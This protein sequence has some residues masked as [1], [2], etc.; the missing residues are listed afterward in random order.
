MQALGPA[1]KAMQ[2]LENFSGMNATQAQQFETAVANNNYAGE[3]QALGSSPQ[4]MQALETFLRHESTQAQQFDTAVANNN[5]AGELQALGSSPQSMQALESF[6]ASQNSDNTINASQN[7]DNAIPTFASGDP[8][9]VSA[10]NY[11]TEYANAVDGSNIPFI[12]PGANTDARAWDSTIP[13]FA[14]GDPSNVSTTNYPTEAAAL[15]PS[16]DPSTSTGYANGAADFASYAAVADGSY[17]VADAVNYPVV[18][19]SYAPGDVAAD[20]ASDASADIASYVSDDIAAYVAAD[21]STDDIA[22]YAAADIANYAAADIANYAAADIANYA[23]SDVANYAAA[24]IA[25]YAAADIASYAAAGYSP[26][27]IASHVKADIASY[28]EADI[29]KYAT[30]AAADSAS[31]VFAGDSHVLS[32]EQPDHQTTYAMDYSTSHDI[33]YTTAVTHD[34]QFAPMTNHQFVNDV[35]S[36]AS[37]AEPQ[38]QWNQASFDPASQPPAVVLSSYNESPGLQTPNYDLVQQAAF[39]PI[40]EFPQPGIMPMAMSDP[41][42]S[43]VVPQSGTAPLGMSDPVISPVIAQPLTPVPT[44][45]DSVFPSDAVVIAQNP[46]AVQ[47]PLIDKA[48]LTGDPYTVAQQAWQSPPLPVVMPVRSVQPNSTPPNGAGRSNRTLASNIAKPQSPRT[49]KQ[50]QGPGY[51][52]RRKDETKNTKTNL[53]PTRPVKNNDLRRKEHQ[54]MTTMRCRSSSILPWKIK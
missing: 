37:C 34:P 42:I 33:D 1:R 32:Y 28:A 19:A 27:D 3:L 29:A 41:L 18:D 43:Q 5:Y 47:Q 45:N 14:T 30:A 2:A 36:A 8:Y 38:T 39:T 48:S 4:S 12:D 52:V 44:A 23:A 50:A 35:A 24:D 21:Y 49:P 26:A 13:T 11:P 16:Y 40:P 17:G 10:T 46:A 15:M 9:S 20:I 51:Y 25:N 31:T 53:T 6:I 7:S 22:S 54:S